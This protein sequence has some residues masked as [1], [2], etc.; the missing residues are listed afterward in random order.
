MQNSFWR[1]P[2]HWTWPLLHIYLPFHFPWTISKDSNAF[3]FISC[4]ST[5][6][7]VQCSDKVAS[8]ISFRIQFKSTSYF[9]M[10]K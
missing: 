8:V 6:W 9:R 1:I 5:F 4:N 2:I 7:I 3:Y 10:K